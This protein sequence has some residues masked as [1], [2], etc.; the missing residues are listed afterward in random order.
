MTEKKATEKQTL[1]QQNANKVA[2]RIK[3]IEEMLA[4]TEAGSIWNEIKNKTID[5]FALP[6]QKISDHAAPTPVEPSKLYLITR[7]TSALPAIETAVGKSYTVELADRFVV[8]ARA[9][10][11]LTRK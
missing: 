11:S 9:V 8:V 4:G 6:D 3:S 7:S 5:M 2:D 1:V 10:A